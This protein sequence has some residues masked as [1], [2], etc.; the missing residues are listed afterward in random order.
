MSMQSTLERNEGT[1][2]VQQ[3]NMYRNNLCYIIKPNVLTVGCC[4]PQRLGIQCVGVWGFKV[5]GVTGDDEVRDV[6]GD[7]VW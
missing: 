5:N 3:S 7:D 2:D 1:P 4:L 6:T